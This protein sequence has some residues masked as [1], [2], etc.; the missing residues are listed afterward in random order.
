MQSYRKRILDIH[1]DLGIPVS[2]E[3][4]HALSLQKEEANLT[5]IG[6]DIY[7]RVQRLEPSAARAWALMKSCAEKDGVTLS[8]VSAFRSVDKQ[9]EIIQRK[10]DMGDS[11]T[12]IL[13]VCAAPGYSEHHTGKALDLTSI[14]CEPLSEEF[15]QTKAF[16]WLLENA[17]M[18]SYS[19]SYPRNNLAGILYEP[20]H[21]AYIGNA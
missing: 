12:E 10:I 9:K 14:G 6:N 20:W 7:G 17:R 16:S 3:H 1:Q 21:W 18:Y 4:D 11:V 19:L 15:D 2:Y 5:E 13:L 8:I